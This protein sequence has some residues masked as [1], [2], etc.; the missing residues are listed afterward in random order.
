MTK[1][2][3]LTTSKLMWNSVLSTKGA[4]Y[5]CLVIK[6]FYLTAPLNQFEYMK[7]PLSLF[8]SWAKEQY[9]LDRL[10]KNGFVYLEMH[11]AVWG[12]PQAGIFGKQVTMQTTP[13][14]WV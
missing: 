1:T 6:I 5:M 14:P 7:I 12:L 8:P 11:C 2:A 4:K 9:N 10:A 3:N 13:P